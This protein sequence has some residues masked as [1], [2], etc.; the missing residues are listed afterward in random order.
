MQPARAARLFGAA[1]GHRE[2]IGNPFKLPERA[3]Y[4]QAIDAT[5]AVLPDD[6]FVAAWDAGRALSLAEA[7]IGCTDSI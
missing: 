2:V 4:D 7:A 3:V 5:R 1:V 6:D